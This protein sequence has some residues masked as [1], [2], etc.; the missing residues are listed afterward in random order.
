MHEFEEAEGGKVGLGDGSCVL[1]PWMFS[2]V[3]E[4]TR[5]LCLTSTR[6]PKCRRKSAP[7]IGFCTSARMKI[8][9]NVR[10]N[11]RSNVCDRVPYV[12]IGVRL[13]AWR[14]KLSCRCVRSMREGGRTLTSAPVSTRN[15]KPDGRS[16]TYN[17]RLS[18]RPATLVV[19]SGW[20]GRL[21]PLENMAICTSGRS[22]HICGGTSTGLGP[23]RGE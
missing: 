11:P 20:P 23:S 13:T 15:L 3:R 2:R 19:A 12:A 17:R 7:R 9:R 5:H 21:T 10:R 6:I 1:I 8:H 22:H 16:V 18:G 4:S 14:L